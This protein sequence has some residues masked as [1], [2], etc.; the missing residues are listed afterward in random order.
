MSRKMAGATKANSTVVV[1][2]LHLLKRVRNLIIRYPKR[3]QLVLV[4]VDAPRAVITEI[5]NSG[6]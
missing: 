5:G 3:I 4:M 1:P 6:L 2:R